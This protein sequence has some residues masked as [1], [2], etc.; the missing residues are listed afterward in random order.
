MFSKTSIL[1]VGACES[2]ATQS[3]LRFSLFFTPLPFSPTP[4]TS[5]LERIPLVIHTLSTDYCQSSSRYL[6]TVTLI[7]EIEATANKVVIRKYASLA[8][9]EKK[10]A[11]ERIG[12]IGVPPSSFYFYLILLS[13][14]APD[15][16]DRTLWRKYDY[17]LFLRVCVC[18]CARVC[19]CIKYTRERN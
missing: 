6:I 9:Y 13:L 3:L 7:R 10:Q 2:F 5:L 17:S 15:S 12:S 1:P 8:S 18:A 19:V 16:R 11:T 4:L 14:R